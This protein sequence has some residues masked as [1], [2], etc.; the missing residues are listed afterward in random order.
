M[1]TTSFLPRRALARSLGFGLAALT[2]VVTAGCASMNTVSSDVS[3]FGQWPT[4]RA[5]GSY[6]F[7]RL[8]SQE[9]RAEDQAALEAAARGAIERAGFKATDAARADVLIQV[10]ARVSRSDRGWDDRMWWPRLSVWG[11]RGVYWGLHGAYP[12][13]PRIDREVAVL[14]RE[15]SSGKALYETRAVSSGFN[16]VDTALLTAMFDAAMKDFPRA[17]V[18]PRR[19]DTQL[20]TADAMPSAGPT[21]EQQKIVR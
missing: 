6:A 8:P 11:G 3:S 14:L 21:P 15:R 13:T 16:S 12:S 2:L 7:E 9:A 20:P 10:A 19:V 1:N 18:S 4:E 5:V 17:A